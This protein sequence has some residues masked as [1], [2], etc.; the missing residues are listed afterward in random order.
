MPLKSPRN[1]RLFTATSYHRIERSAK[2]PLIA[3]FTNA[4]EAVGFENPDEPF[5]GRAFYRKPG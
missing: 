3:F 4:T 2:P 5:T 1:S